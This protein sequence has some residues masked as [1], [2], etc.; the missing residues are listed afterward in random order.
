MIYNYLMADYVNKENYRYNPTVH[1]KS[2]LKKIYSDIVKLSKDS[3]SYLFEN[4]TDVQEFALQL[5]EG[6]LALQSTLYNLQK[7]DDS[8]AF[9]YK[10]VNSDNEKSLTTT[11]DTEDH[12]KLPEPFTIDIHKLATRQHNLGNYVYCSTSRFQEGTYQF[13]IDVEEDSY[14]F[15]LQ[16]YGKTTNE[17]ALNQIVHAINQ[18]DVPITATN[19]YDKSHDKIRI[20]LTSDHTGSTNGDS[21]FHCSDISHPSTSPGCVEHFNLNNIVQ[22]PTNSSFSINGDEKSTL[23][24]EFTLNNALHLT[25]H[26][27]TQTPIHINYDTSAEKVMTEL[28]DIANIYNKLIHLSYHQ[29]TPPKLASLMLHDLKN[30]FSKSKGELKDCGITFNDDGYMEIDETISNDAA[31]KGKFQKLFGSPDTLGGNALEVFKGIAMNPMK[32]VE[33]KVIVAYPNPMRENFAN[34]YMTS[35][36]SGMLFNSYC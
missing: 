15:Q 22:Y 16:L 35:I 7:T 14:L 19:V 2:E 36:Y 33:N 18:S 6:S 1:K 30:V 3:P 25:L 11:I 4:S 23:S 10:Q 12:S 27:P 29:G 5:K 17:D 24:N 8:S 28:T 32:Y 26:S 34:P 9:F 13:Q 21:I 20:S 31:T